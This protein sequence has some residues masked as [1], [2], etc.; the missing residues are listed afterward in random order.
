MKLFR[1]VLVAFA[2]I[3][4]A[5]P[6]MAQQHVIKFTPGKLLSFG[7]SNTQINGFTIEDKLKVGIN[8]LMLGYEYVVSEK[9]TIGADIKIA[10]PSNSSNLNFIN[11]T[12]SSEFGVFE[13]FGLSSGFSFTPQVRFY[14]GDNGA[15]TG[16]YLNPWLRFFSYKYTSDVSWTEI[17]GTSDITAEATYG[18]FG[19]G[20]SI[21]WQWLLGES[22]VI[23]WNMGLGVLPTRIGLSGT[24]T[25]PLATDVQEFIDELNSAFE[26]FPGEINS[27]IEK[28]GDGVEGKTGYF[29]LPVFR[30]NLSIGYA[31]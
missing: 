19:G 22:I 13:N 4:M 30:S 3:L 16:F 9:V 26:E 29:A 5:T 15:P 1:T 25:G 10:F 6:M 12:V 11:D 28:I 18:G 24:V 20:F 17:A 7:G 31:F 2:A 8:N 27:Q 14:L 23:D 21:G